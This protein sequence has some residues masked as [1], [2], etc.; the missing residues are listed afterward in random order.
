MNLKNYLESASVDTPTLVYDT[1]MN[2]LVLNTLNALT[3][4]ATY[5]ERQNYM[6]L[7]KTFINLCK[8]I[9]YYNGETSA[10]RRINAKIMMSCNQFASYVFVKDQFIDEFKKALT[11]V[12]NLYTNPQIYL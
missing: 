7:V 5:A 9:T 11:M 10:M 4:C 8:V 3:T 2:E 6:C 12:Y 1:S